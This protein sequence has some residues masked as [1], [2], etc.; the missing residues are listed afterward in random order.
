M[1]IDFSVLPE[2]KKGYN[3]ANGSKKCVIY[4]GARYMVKFPPTAR[5]NKD[6]S[7]FGN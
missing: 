6:D 7:V 4:N 3:G 5:L 1:G 2:T